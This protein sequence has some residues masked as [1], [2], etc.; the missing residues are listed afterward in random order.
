MKKLYSPPLIDVTSIVTQNVL[1]A[2]PKEDNFIGLDPT[3]FTKIGG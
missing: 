1:S 2:S 3:W